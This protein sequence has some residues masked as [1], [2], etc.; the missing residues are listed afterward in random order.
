MIKIN[1]PEEKLNLGL[2]IAR[3]HFLYQYPWE[4]TLRETYQ[5]VWRPSTAVFH[6]RCEVIKIA[7][8][9]RIGDGAVCLFGL[10]LG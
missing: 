9:H 8:E 3:H 2:R 7:V 6:P 4:V 5:W 10:G 1:P